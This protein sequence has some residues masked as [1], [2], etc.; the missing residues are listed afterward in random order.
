MMDLS[1]WVLGVFE[2]SSLYPPPVLTVEDARQEL[3]ELEELEGVP[4]G[5]TPERFMQEW[6]LLQA[7]EASRKR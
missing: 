1:L 5:M 4:K 3:E 2:G 7:K 6:N